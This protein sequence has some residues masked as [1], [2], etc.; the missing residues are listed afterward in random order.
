MLKLL[1]QFN[2]AFGEG[3]GEV[4]RRSCYREALFLLVTAVGQSNIEFHLFDSYWAKAHSRLPEHAAKLKVV[5]D[6]TPSRR[7]FNVR[8]TFGELPLL[9]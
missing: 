8:Q 4:V 1:Y 3:E 6:Q 2:D 5:N 9:Y 7:T